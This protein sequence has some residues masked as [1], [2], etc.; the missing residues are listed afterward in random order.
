MKR[1]NDKISSKYRIRWFG[2]VTEVK[3][4]TATIGNFRR[5]CPVQSVGSVRFGSVRLPFLPPTSAG[6]KT[7]QFIT[8]KFVDFHMLNYVFSYYSF[9]NLANNDCKAHWMI[10]SNKLLIIFLE[11]SCNICT[12]PQNR[13]LKNYG[14][15]PLVIFDTVNLDLGI[16][17]SLNC[18]AFSSPFQYLCSAFST[19]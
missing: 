7:R 12:P 8:K 3:P 6:Y 17:L 10:I 19:L 4:G 18:L 13:V 5:L 2:S 14:K 15:T 1:N 11:E 16:Y 9:Q